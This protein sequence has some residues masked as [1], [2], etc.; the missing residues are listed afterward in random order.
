MHK[1][2]LYQSV[3]KISKNFELKKTNLSVLFKIE[4]VFRTKSFNF[5]ITVFFVR[6]LKKLLKICY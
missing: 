1:N 6:T 5:K 4:N 3:V 2:H